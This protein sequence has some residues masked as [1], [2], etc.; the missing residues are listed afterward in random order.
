M[1]KGIARQRKSTGSCG[2]NFGIEWDLL[3]LRSG[4]EHRQL[5][6]DPCQLLSMTDHHIVPTLS[7]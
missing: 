6:A 3:S 5:R 7:M 2:Q 4:S 1:N